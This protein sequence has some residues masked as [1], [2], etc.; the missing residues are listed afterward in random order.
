MC[1]CVCV[2]VCMCMHMSACMCAGANGFQKRVSYPGARI[3]Q[4]SSCE[5]LGVGSED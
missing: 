5:L 4:L 3:T 2:R 1:V